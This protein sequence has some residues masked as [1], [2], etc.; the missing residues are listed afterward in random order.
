MSYLYD[1]YFMLSWSIS[2][3]ESLH[4]FDALYRCPFRHTT[5]DL[6]V[7]P[8]FYLCQTDFNFRD[9]PAAPLEGGI[10]VQLEKQGGDSTWHSLRDGFICVC[11]YLCFFCFI[12]HSC[13]IIVSMVGWTWWDWSLI[14]WTYL[15]SVLWHCWLGHLT[16]K[17][18]SLIWPIMCLVG[19]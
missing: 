7:S 12:L 5:H 13:C 3:F 16:R 4:Q 15:S 18:P 11:V 2:C 10:Y 19:R 17:N 14:L 8:L 9:G 1:M 6:Y